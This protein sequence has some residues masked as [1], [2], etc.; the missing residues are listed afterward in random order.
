MKYSL[1]KSISKI[2]NK[3]HLCEYGITYDA[4][5]QLNLIILYIIIAI[6]KKSIELLNISNKNLYKNLED[7]FNISFHKNIKLTTNTLINT[8]RFIF[9]G[10][11]MLNILKVGN[12]CLLNLCS[13]QSGEYHINTPNS[14]IQI[15]SESQYDN[16][17]S[18]LFFKGLAD[19][20]NLKISTNCEYYLASIIEYLITE[21]LEI[22]SIQ[23]Y[24]LKL[25]YIDRRSLYLALCYDKD[26]YYL[27][28]KTSINII[29]SGVLPSILDNQ[30]IMYYQ[31]TYDLLLSKTQF[32]IMIRTICNNI[33]GN[34]VKISKNTFIFLQYYL[35][36]FIIKLL[37]N[38]NKL[39]LTFKGNGK[40]KISKKDIEFAFNYMSL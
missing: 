38:T 17:I 22:S 11:L 18:S 35:E 33:E 10:D 9:T 8:I 12:T 30:T 1:I 24:K 32:I 6:F 21:I 5:I 3:A 34:N 31:N 7:G 19:K 4:K 13:D 40:N 25:K 23:A 39:C 36:D 29:G 2:L 15:D 20:Y 27:L 26:F 37:Y 16:V 28:K 14:E